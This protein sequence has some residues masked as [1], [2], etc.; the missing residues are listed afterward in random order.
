MITP[1]SDSDDW[2][3]P[4][5]D[6]VVAFR[7]P[8]KGSGELARRH[9]IPRESRITFD[10]ET[11]TY[12][13]DGVRV[14]RSVTGLLHD[15]AWTFDPML[16][17]C[18]MKSG[19]GWESKRAALETQGLGTED[20][21]FLAR[22]EFNSRVARCRGHCLHWQCEQ[23]CNGRPVEKPHSPEFQQACQIYDFFLSRGY[24]P[25]RTEAGRLHSLQCMS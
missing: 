11:H 17:V 9:P 18:A 14:P 20:A 3:L 6:F 7:L 13:V 8:R 4:D 1:I 10:E 22:W 24:K 25:Y 23:M 12:T 2:R 15:Y 5:A 16:A 21:D 19:R